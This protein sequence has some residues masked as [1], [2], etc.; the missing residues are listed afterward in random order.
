MTII[1]KIEFIIDHI[2]PLGQGVFKKGDDIFFIPKTLPNESGSAF[3]LKK[4]KGVHFAELDE[5]TQVSEARIE[6]EC[7]HFNNCPGCHFFHCD[8]NSQLFSVRRS[9][10]FNAT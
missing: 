8:Y 7:S 5:L 9:V 2:D 1:K 6:S 4:K 10:P 3:V